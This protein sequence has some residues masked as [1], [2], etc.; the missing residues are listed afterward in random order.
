MDS[1]KAWVAT[2]GGYFR[3]SEALEV[4]YRDEQLR[5][6]VRAGVLV[7]LRHGY[8]AFADLVEALDEVGRYR[9]L[10][11]AVLHRLGPDYA[12]V[13][14]SACAAYGIDLYDADLSTVHVACLTGK[15]GRREAGV[16]YHERTF[17]PDTE[18]VDVGGAKI[19]IPAVSLWTAACTL[20][21]EGALVAINSALYQNLVDEEG[22]G[23]LA[24]RFE[25]W[26]GSRTARLALRMS[27]RRIESPGESRAFFLFWSFHLPRPQP[28]FK[29]YNDAG[30][31]IARTDFGW[32]EYRH[33]CE[34]DGKVKYMR[35]FRPDV[36]PEQIVFEEK[37]RED[38]VRDEAF[39]VSR[40]IS[41][42]LRGP[43]RV[44]TA[45]TL[46]RSLERSAKLYTKN[47]TIIAS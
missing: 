27:D 31:L 18:V 8:Y 45:A 10:C 32:E 1:F 15:A 19:T 5:A 12:L 11:R 29:I 36:P 6:A 43:N 23:G 30:R 9:L 17:D 34:F 28:Q 40:L 46:V 44:R 38:L 14:V 22:L 7:R 13:G 39:G 42:D 24:P 47:R 20:A 21:T 37:R 41:D 3:R 33:V 2:R 4:G 25:K 26:P 16:H 35:L